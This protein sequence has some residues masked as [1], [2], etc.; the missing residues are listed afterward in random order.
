MITALRELDMP[1]KSITEYLDKRTP[2]E[3]I[4]LLTEQEKL[5]DIKIK[6]LQKLKKF[7]KDKAALTEAACK[8]DP[9]TITLEHLPSELLILT[10][11]KEKGDYSSMVLSLS[12][13]I[14]FCRQHKIYSSYSMGWTL[15]LESIL[16]KEYFKS[17]YLYTQIENYKNHPPALVKKEGLYLMAY[18]KDGSYTTEAVYTRILDFIKVNA[19][20]VESDFYEEVLLD[21]LSMKGYENYIL[22]VSVMVSR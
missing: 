18:H 14:T 4:N 19:L 7:V 21:E 11:F 16:A 8:A 15:S 22:K 9:L 3:F 20:K 2:S 6:H 17:N 1:L 13:H 12:E 10:P 5:I